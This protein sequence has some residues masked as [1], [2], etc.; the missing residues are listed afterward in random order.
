MLELWAR[1]LPH[2][3]W[4]KTFL[5]DRGGTSFWH[6]TYFMR[7]GMEAVYIDMWQ[8]KGLLRVAPVQE[9][10]GSMFSARRRLRLEGAETS[11]PAV[12]EEAL[13]AGK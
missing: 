5:A 2:Q 4:W 12:D 8:P 13:Y 9:A 6:E 11:A 7:G 3:R 10:R 1:T